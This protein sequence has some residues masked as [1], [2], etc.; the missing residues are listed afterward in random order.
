[1]KC[2]AHNYMVEDFDLQ[3]LAGPNQVAGHFDVGIRRRTVPRYAACGI[4]GITLFI[5]LF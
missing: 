3:E 1:M 5:T 2:L 4:T